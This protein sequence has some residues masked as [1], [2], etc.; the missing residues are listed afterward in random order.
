MSSRQ[1]RS[2]SRLSP[3]GT[4]MPSVSRSTVWA[5]TDDAAVSTSTSGQALRMVCLQRAAVGRR[6]IAEPSRRGSAAVCYAR[7][8]PRRRRRSR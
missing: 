7:S 3:T 8:R 2:S 4:A 1:T 5:D 6:M